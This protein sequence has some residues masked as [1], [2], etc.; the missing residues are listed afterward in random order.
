MRWEVYFP[1][2]WDG[3]NLDSP[4]HKTH[5]SYPAIGDFNGGVC[6]ISHPVALLSIFFEFFF[7]TGVFPDTDKF[8]FANG[9][10]TGFGFHGDFVMGWTNRTLLQTAHHDCINSGNCPTL[11]NQGGKRQPLI[12]PAIYEEEVGLNGPIPKLPGNNPI[13]WPNGEIGQ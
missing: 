2:C 8:A 13:V 5:M 1:S 12:F 6:P 3:V 9:D 4:D 10:T 7:I 11:G